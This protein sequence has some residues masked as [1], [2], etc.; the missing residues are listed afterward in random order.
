MGRRYAFLGRGARAAA[1]LIFRICVLAAS[2]FRPR[3]W[4]AQSS[5]GAPGLVGEDTR[6][7]EHAFLRCAS[8]S[9]FWPVPQLGLWRMTFDAGGLSLCVGE[10]TV[11]SALTAACVEATNGGD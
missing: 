9:S 1:I 2:C 3:S 8:A 5:R 11:E 4:S 10:S 7:R 6:D